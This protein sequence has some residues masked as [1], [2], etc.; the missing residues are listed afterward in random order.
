MSN[1]CRRSQVSRNAAWRKPLLG[2]AVAVGLAGCAA[3]G[4]SIEVYDQQ[5]RANL[6][7]TAV[8]AAAHS[9]NPGRVD[10]LER[11]AAALRIACAALQD[12]EYRSRND[13]PVDLSV[14][15]A[16]YGTLDTCAAKATEIEDLLW[17]IDPFI[18]GHYLE[19]PMVSVAENDPKARIDLYRQPG[20]AYR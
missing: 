10:D 15:V 16:A 12:A 13:A 9:K 14:K 11:G 20:F 7:L 2:A 18:A 5:A 1:R 19:H 8:L 6:A 4:Q 17:R 3:A